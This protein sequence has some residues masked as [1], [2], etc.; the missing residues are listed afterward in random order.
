[1]VWMRTAALPNFRKLYRRIDHTGEL[2]NGLPDK[3][4]SFIIEYRK[5]NFFAERPEHELTSCVRDPLLLKPGC[6]PIYLPYISIGHL[7][8]QL[9]PNVYQ[10]TSGGPFDHL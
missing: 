1:M 9:A 5:Q 8:L 4:F 10:L 2:E 3:K 6:E 7:K